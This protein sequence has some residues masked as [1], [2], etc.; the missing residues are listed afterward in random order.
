V[1]SQEG[2]RL[3]GEGVFGRNSDL[4]LIGPEIEARSEKKKRGWGMARKLEKGSRRGGESQAEFFRYA[5]V[6]V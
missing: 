4:G 3:E 2:G 5:G 1:N 6:L